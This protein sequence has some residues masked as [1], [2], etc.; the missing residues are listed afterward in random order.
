MESSG[1]SKCKLRDT[2]AQQRSATIALLLGS[3]TVKQGKT[4]LEGTGPAEASVP[5]KKRPSF[6]LSSPCSGAFEIS[7]ERFRGAILDQ[8]ERGFRRL[9]P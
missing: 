8:R 4:T 6:G 9:A 1:T 7:Q 2:Q 3:Q 5:I